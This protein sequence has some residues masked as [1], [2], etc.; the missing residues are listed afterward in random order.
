MFKQLKDLVRLQFDAMRQSGKL[1]ATDTDRDTIWQTYLAAFSDATRQEHNCNCCKSFIRQVG[2][3]VILKPDL[4][5][6]SVW[7]VPMNEVPEEYRESIKALADYVKSRPITGLFL[8]TEK[9]VGKDRNFSEKW[10]VV[11]EHFHVNIPA[12]LSSD[13]MP[14]IAGNFRATK[15][16]F[17]RG[18][19][20]IHTDAA[21]TVKELIAQNSLYR[22]ADYAH[23]IDELLK[24][25]KEFAATSALNRENYCW[26]KVQS[27]A[28]ATA[29]VRNTAIGT[30]LVDLSEGKDLEVAVRAF[31]RMVAPANYKRPTALVTPRMVEDAKKKLGDLGMLSALERRRLDTRDL[32][33]HNALFVHRG[34]TATKDVFAQL[35]D[36]TQVKVQT[37]SKCEEIPISKFIADVLPTAKAVRVLVENR[38]LANLVTLTGAVDPDAAGIFKWDTSFGWSY[39]GGVAD[40]VKERVKAAGGNVDGWMRISLSWSNY[41]DLDLNL[42]GLGDIVNFINKRSPK[43]CAQLDVDM[44]AGGGSTRE[45][46]EN[47]HITRQLPAGQYVI[48]VNQFHKR[49]SSDTGYELEI[50]VGGECKLVSR[51]KSPTGTDYFK[52]TVNSEGGVSFDFESGE[53][54]VV[55]KTKW[56]VTTNR[57]VNVKAVTLSPNHWGQPTGN[58]HWFFMLE[59]C[60]SDEDTRPFYN[61]FLCDKLTENRKVMEVLAGKITVADAEGAELSGLGFSETIRNHFYVEVEGAFKRV[62]KVTI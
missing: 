13:R 43:L 29:R 61:E 57:W 54:K 56:G 45:P 48:G 24:C 62:V 30:L 11:F 4:T 16:V 59:G 32:G 33:P 6:V 28:E 31:E 38:H 60:V 26:M 41:D 58:K 9:E 46:V 17:M 20:E 49:E 25:K 18:L 8:L 1:L 50:E 21:Q 15:E 2:S 10:Q 19:T 35:A 36:D 5:L 7:D 40:S 14:T 52:F 53:G 34:K 12:E 44:N 39:T 55:S 3:A 51:S 47:I 22:G 42:Q 23:M 27:V 37:F